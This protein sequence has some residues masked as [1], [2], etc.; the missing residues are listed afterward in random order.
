MPGGAREAMSG[1]IISLPVLLWHGRSGCTGHS[2]ST[3]FLEQDQSVPLILWCS[4]G[5]EASVLGW[6]RVHWDL[7]DG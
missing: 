6:D 1:A 7:F 3:P 4:N 2:P 5:S